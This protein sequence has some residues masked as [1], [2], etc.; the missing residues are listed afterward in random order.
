MLRISDLWAKIVGNESRLHFT[1]NPYSFGEP[2]AEKESVRQMETEPDKN[3]P[4]VVEQ[5]K[6]GACY[7]VW[8]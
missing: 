1:L 6:K 7:K 8:I 2:T 4:I 5:L 3:K